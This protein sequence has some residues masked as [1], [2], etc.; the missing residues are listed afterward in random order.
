MPLAKNALSR[1]T[2]DAMWHDSNVRPYRPFRRDLV[3][4]A[5]SVV[6]QFL[7]L[8]LAATVAFLWFVE[9]GSRAVDIRG[10]GD[11][12]FSFVLSATLTVLPTAALWMLYRVFR[13]AFR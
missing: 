4:A 8:W 9:A 10:F 1:Y 2:R 5:R 12:L 13:F 3:G 11:L 6:R 7:L